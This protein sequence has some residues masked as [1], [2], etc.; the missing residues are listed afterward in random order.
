[1]A[2]ITAK[3][4]MALREATTLPMMLCKKALVEAEGD[5]DK[6]VDILK[7]DVENV[8]VKRAD[9]ETAEGR[10]FTLVADDG[11]EAVMVEVQCES[12]PVG[13]GENLAVVSR[14]RNCSTNWLT[15]YAKR[16]L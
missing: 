16:L 6:A 1:M 14:C 7:R 4:V 12:A 2:E 13:S 5:F 11:S 15:K 3:A 9:N 8:K 10:V